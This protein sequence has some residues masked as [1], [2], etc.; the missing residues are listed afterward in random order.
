MNDINKKSIILFDGVC[1]LCNSSVTFVI[2]RD[3]KNYFIFSSLQSD[4]AKDILL[5]CGIKKNDLNTIILVD[6]GVVYSKSTAILKI[7]KKLN[8]PW[9]F[10]YIFIILP[11]SFR[12]TI[13]DHVAKNRYRWFGKRKECMVPTEDLKNRFL[14]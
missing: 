14:V 8:G 4:A 12:D 6:R 5:Q 13:Y 3:K 10:F 7:V 11:K 2:K 1:N 9:K